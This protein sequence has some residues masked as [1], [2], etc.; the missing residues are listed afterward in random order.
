[1]RPV[2]F[3]VIVFIILA[4]GWGKSLN[5]SK[6]VENIGGNRLED[7]S[8]SGET[9]VTD[10]HLSNQEIHNLVRLTLMDYIYDDGPDTTGKATVKDV[11]GKIE[12]K[13]SRKKRGLMTRIAGNNA[14]TI[15]S[16][17]DSHNNP[18]M[19][20]RFRTYLQRMTERR[21]LRAEQ[22]RSRWQLIRKRQQTFFKNLR[23]P[24]A[25]S[26]SSLTKNDANAPSSQPPLRMLTSMKHTNAK[27]PA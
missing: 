4:Q 12:V 25:S 21:R 3:Y 15:S 19:G 23:K 8:G 9:T 2:L 20:G 18:V 16:N 22:R 11:L 7:F 26:S 24:H 6:E 5:K 17:N 10:R 27:I 1:M 14:N 13:A